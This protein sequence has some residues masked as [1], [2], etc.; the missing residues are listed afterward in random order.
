M[1]TT[2]HPSTVDA[3]EDREE[4][5]DSEADDG[6]YH[7][8]NFGTGQTIVAPDMEHVVLYRSHAMIE[9]IQHVCELSDGRNGV[10]LDRGYDADEEG[11][12]EEY[13]RGA[14]LKPYKN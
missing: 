3:A 11:R 2:A 6:T 1:A 14:G 7:G 8:T 10:E 5:D 12:D 9:P 13:K 4:N